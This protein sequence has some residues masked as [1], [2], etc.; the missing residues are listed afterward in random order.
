MSE[1]LGAEGLY[2]LGIGGTTRPG[3][4]TE[5]ALRMALGVAAAAGAETE[6]L[7]GSPIDLP[8]YAPENTTRSPEA[9]RLVAALRRAD[10]III[11]SPAY[12]GGLSGLVKN[13]LDYAEDLREDERPYAAFDGL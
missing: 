13:A 4:T 3:S 6:L 9:E 7:I 1:Q 11:A 10:G 12:H 5:R 8:L 2:I